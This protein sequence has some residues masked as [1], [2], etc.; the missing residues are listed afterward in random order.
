MK[1]IP[2]QSC[3]YLLVAAFAFM[4]GWICGEQSA[5]A[6]MPKRRSLSSRTNSNKPA[7]KHSAR[8][9]LKDG[10]VLNDAHKH[11]IAV[12]KALKKPAR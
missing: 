1:K 2:L 7:P 12:S 4:I 3:C 5:A 9:Q 10:S 11:I 6:R 8:R